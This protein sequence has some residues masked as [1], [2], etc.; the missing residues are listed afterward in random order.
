[1]P[2]CIRPKVRL[3]FDQNVFCVVIVVKKY[4][5]LVQ[6]VFSHFVAKSK[7]PLV[8]TKRVAN[9]LLF[10]QQDRINRV[11]TRFYLAIYAKLQTLKLVPTD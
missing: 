5:M 9:S 2:N 8:L 1:M 11:V 10:R 4:I 7:I 6:V 3:P